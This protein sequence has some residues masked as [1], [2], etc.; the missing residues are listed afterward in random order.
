[1]PLQV[2]FYN[3]KIQNIVATCDLKFPIKLEN[4]NHIHGQF[5][6]YEPELYPGLIYRMVAPRVVLL[7][8]V[9]GKIVLTGEIRKVF[10]PLLSAS[11][12]IFILI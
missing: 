7:I 1:M 10:F 2:K 11:I 4:L 12:Q 8:F 3:F 6:S 5:S 9:N